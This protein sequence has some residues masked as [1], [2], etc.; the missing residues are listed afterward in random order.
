MLN[1][2]ISNP[3]KNPPQCQVKEVHQSLDP[4]VG[5]VKSQEE[6]S[7]YCQF[8]SCVEPNSS[9]TASWATNQDS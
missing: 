8:L 5:M 1:S 7:V 2:W 9:Q 3:Q 4:L 6:L